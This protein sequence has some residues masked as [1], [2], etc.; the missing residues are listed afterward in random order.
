MIERMIKEDMLEK[1]DFGNIPNFR[2]IDE[3][4]INLSFDPA[5]EYSVPYK[6]GTN[7]ILYNTEMVNKVVDSWDIL[8]DE[9]FARQI[10]MYLGYI[11][12][13]SIWTRAY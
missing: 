6:W 13:A 2:Y 4:F 12:G 9:D 1:I 5:G 10:I 3:R 11:I 7:G 8:W